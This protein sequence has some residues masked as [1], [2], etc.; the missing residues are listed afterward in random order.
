MCESCN[1]F[2]E[3]CNTSLGHKFIFA[4][5]LKYFINPS[6]RAR[7]KIRKTNQVL[8]NKAR[9]EKHYVHSKRFFRRKLKILRTPKS[10]FI[11]MKAGLKQS[12]HPEAEK[13][14]SR[15]IK[16]NL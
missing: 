2:Q 6:Q 13:G 14:T 12:K 4:R 5:F 7:Q 8:I 10:R 3:L 1:I 15:Q 16:I 11:R 9:C